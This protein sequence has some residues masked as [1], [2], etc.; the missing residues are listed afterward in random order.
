[1]NPVT[2]Q[3]MSTRSRHR[4]SKK[5]APAVAEAPSNRTPGTVWRRLG[6]HCERHR[7]AWINGLTALILLGLAIYIAVVFFGHRVVPNSDL[8]AFFKTGYAVLSLKWPTSF[9]RTP[10]L[11]ILQILV[12]KLTVTP[13]PELTGARILN[14]IL[15]PA[16]ILLLWLVARRFVGRFCIPT[17]WISLL[18]SVYGIQQLWQTITTRRRVPMLASFMAGVVLT[19]GAIIRSI[20]L[21]PSLPRIATI[22]PKARMLPVTAAALRS[23]F[24]RSNYMGKIRGVHAQAYVLPYQLLAAPAAT[25]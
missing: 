16:N 3:H 4:S 21:W 19:L 9:Q 14:V 22:C 6:R 15:Y 18:L 24:I 23:F 1:M 2:N 10:L 7:N 20:S 12:G 8:P 5:D 13:T 17:A 25:P 11:G